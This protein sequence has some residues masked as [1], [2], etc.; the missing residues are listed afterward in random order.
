[1]ATKG[2]AQGSPDWIARHQRLRHGLSVVP[3]GGGRHRVAGR[4]IRPLKVIGR[5]R[6][7]ALENT[8]PYPQSLAFPQPLDAPHQRH[9]MTAK[10]KT[11]PGRMVRPSRVV[12]GKH[13]AG[14]PKPDTA[15]GGKEQAPRC[16]HELV[17]ELLDDPQQTARR[18][19]W[20][21]VAS[22]VGHARG[23]RRRAAG[24]PGRCR[25]APSRGGG[26]VDGRTTGAG[27]QRG[28]R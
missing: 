28:R 7:G 2:S 17:G 22:T 6:S 12:V 10:P 8:A 21:V 3:N 20:S 4:V 23:V 9:N 16:V 18:A 19:P 27:G 14:R 1:M 26:G 25:R 15:C 11:E 24:R 5:S 13:E